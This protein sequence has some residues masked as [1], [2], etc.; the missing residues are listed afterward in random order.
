MPGG[1]YTNLKFQA[2]ANGLGEEW[3]NIKQSY[4]TANQCLGDIVKVTPSSKVVGDMAQYLVTNKI[5]DE[6][7]LPEQADSL[8]FL[9]CRALPRLLANRWVPRTVTHESLE[10]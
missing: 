2:F 7:T 8:S 4:A 6:E 9:T 10:R 3:D 1:Q 5:W